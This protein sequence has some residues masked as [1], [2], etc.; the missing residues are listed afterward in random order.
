MAQVIRIPLTALSVLVAGCSGS[1]SPDASSTAPATGAD[2]AR[3][4]ETACRDKK[5][6]MQALLLAHAS[7]VADDDCI[8]VASPC[9]DVVT[10]PRD[11]AG[12]YGVN[13]EFD[14]ERFGALDGEL[15]QC[16]GDVACPQCDLRSPAARC[17]AGSCVPAP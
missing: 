15:R 14:Q 8:L 13:V 16:L 4:A 6:Q 5:E 7:C 12:Q 2:A 17:E 3:D 1:T 10:L 9:L 11:C